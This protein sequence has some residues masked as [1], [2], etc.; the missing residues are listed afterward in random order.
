MHSAWPPYPLEPD[1]LISDKANLANEVDG[2]ICQEVPNRFSP[3]TERCVRSVYKGE[4]RAPESKFVHS[5]YTALQFA[6][7]RHFT[8][9]SYTDESA[10]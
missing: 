8:V 6:D 10:T 4:G 1:S 2:V 5:L 7:F 3:A 9:F